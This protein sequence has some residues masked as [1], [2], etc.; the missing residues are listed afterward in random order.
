[1]ITANAAPTAG[2]RKNV[3]VLLSSQPPKGLQEAI[4]QHLD[5]RARNPDGALRPEPGTL[6]TDACVRFDDSYP[7]AKKPHWSLSRASRHAPA[8]IAE[9]I[10]Q[11]LSLKPYSAV[12]PNRLDPVIGYQTREIFLPPELP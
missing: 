4:F 6:Q 9:H 3:M 5:A 12:K 11:P 2:T 7:R 10:L 8:V 1:M